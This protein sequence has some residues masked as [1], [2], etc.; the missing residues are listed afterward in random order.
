[1]KKYFISIILFIVLALSACSSELPSPDNFLFRYIDAN[2]TVQMD[3][4]HQPDY[5]GI[6]WQVYPTD[7]PYEWKR[8]ILTVYL[9]NNYS[10]AL[11]VHAGVN[12]EAAQPGFYAESEIVNILPDEKKP[13]DITL[14]ICPFI[15]GRVETLKT[16][17]L[18]WFVELK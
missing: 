18:W 9:W 7:S 17:N 13:I 3:E 6:D 15:L 11:K 16:V 4:E 2:Y 1:M 10:K 5:S 12:L 14:K 8:G